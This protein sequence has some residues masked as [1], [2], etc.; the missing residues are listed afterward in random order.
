MSAV[1]WGVGCDGEK[2]ILYER[3]LLLIERP[4]RGEVTFFFNGHPCDAA[5]AF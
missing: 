2:G 3:L 1:N 4:E 5:P